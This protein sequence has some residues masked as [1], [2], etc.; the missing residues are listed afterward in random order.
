MP[1][2]QHR[3]SPGRGKTAPKNQPPWIDESGE[4][5]ADSTFIRAHFERKYT[6]ALDAG[7]TSLDRAQ[8]WASIPP[9]STP[10]PSAYWPDP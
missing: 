3:R 2:L 1:G 8:V 5:I 6:L 9:V 4:R 7:R 10:S